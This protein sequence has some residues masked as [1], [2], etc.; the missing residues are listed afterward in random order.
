MRKWLVVFSAASVVGCMNL[1]PPPQKSKFVVVSELGET[2]QIRTVGLTVFGNAS[3]TVEVSAWH[4]DDHAESAAL[5]ALR[6]AGY[7]ASVGGAAARQAVGEV[8]HSFV[9]GKHG[10]AGGV[11]GLRKAAGGADFVLVVAPDTANYGQTAD[12]FFH[13]NQRINGFGVYR[14][15][16]SQIDFAHFALYLFD[17]RTGEERSW[18]DNSGA[19]ERPRGSWLDDE[20]LPSKD[21]INA[22]Q[23][24]LLKLVADVE[25]AELRKLH[26]LDVV[27]E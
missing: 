8:S 26:L 6:Q 24:Q 22:S 2:L 12:P 4:V 9:T 23:A 11:E 10:V 14:R 18:G 7:D 5:A 21:V 15:G 16:N 1:Q 17:V 3:S 27:Q 19:D 25:V 20:L 13:T